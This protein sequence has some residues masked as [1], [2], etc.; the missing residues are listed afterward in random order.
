LQQ[1]LRDVETNGWIV[2]ESKL[3]STNLPAYFLPQEG[4]FQYGRERMAVPH[5]RPNKALSAHAMTR[6]N[7]WL[8]VRRRA[9]DAGI[10]GRNHAMTRVNAWLMVRRRAEDAGIAG[11]NGCHTIRATG[12]IAYLKNGGTINRAQ[13]LAGNTNLK[14]IALDDRRDDEISVEE[15]ERIGI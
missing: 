5:E 13:E 11:R 1:F 3:L 7:A 15:V 4:R 8:M 6:V 12:I 14:T 9:E 10:T 2:K